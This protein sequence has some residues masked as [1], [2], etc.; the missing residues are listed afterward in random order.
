MKIQNKVIVVTGAGNGIA[1]DVTLQLLK[2]GASVA[3]IDVNEANLIETQTLAGGPNQ[4]LS[5]HVVDIS[6]Q[7][8]V[9]KLPKAVVA[10]HGQVDGL[11]N[12]AGII[13]KFHKVA[14]LSYEDFHRVFNVNFFGTVHMV[15]EF[16]PL[17]SAR[18]EAQILNVSSMGGYVPVPGQTIYGAS[19]AA[20]KL[21]TEGL[22]SELADTKIGVCLFFPGAIATNISTNSKAITAKE[23]KAMAA[24]AGDFKTLPSPEAAA[25]I[26]EAFEQNRF[27]GFAGSDAKIMDKLSR[28][29]PEQA[30]KIIQKQMAAL[31]G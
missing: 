9:A 13:H 23:A 14:D 5:L 30:A 19:K 8:A 24:K 4:K 17:L 6:D 31:L 29:M 16:L 3:A 1:R 15:K 28:L 27:H 22:R 21:F 2:A 18:S 26:I 7:A 25:A 10:K 12:I 11:M 20:V